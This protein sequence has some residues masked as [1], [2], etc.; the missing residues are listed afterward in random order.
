MSPLPAYYATIARER[1][2]SEALAVAADD[3]EKVR[4]VLKDR[5]AAALV[6][7]NF[8]G[9]NHPD[10][11]KLPAEVQAALFEVRKGIQ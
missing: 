8:I 6:L 7:H 4:A 9:N 2:D 1:G 3:A 10:M 11:A 5:L